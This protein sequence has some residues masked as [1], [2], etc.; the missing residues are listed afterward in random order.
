VQCSQGMTAKLPR[1]FSLKP[2]NN[3]KRCR[4]LSGWDSR[5]RF[6]AGVF[7]SFLHFGLDGGVVANH[8]SSLV[9]WHLLCFCYFGMSRFRSGS[10]GE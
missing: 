1:G 7:F 3:K 10:L 9:S 4:F 2:V 5:G 6:S 8:I